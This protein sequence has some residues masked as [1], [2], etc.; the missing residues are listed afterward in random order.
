[1]QMTA[2]S[3]VDSIRMDMIANMQIPIPPTL[4]E[5]TAIA[6]TLLD[7]EALITSIEKLIDKKRSI[8]QGAMQQLLQ[9]KEG[10]EIKSIIELAENKKDLFNDGDWIESEY[11]TNKGIRLIQTGNIGIGSFVEK[12]N[13]KYINEESF[14]KLNCKELKVGD[15]LICRLAEPAGRAC[16][17]P[18]IGEERVITSVDVTIFRPNIQLVNRSFLNQIFSTNNWFNSISDLCGGTTHKRISRGALG[19]IKIQLPMIEEQTRIATILSDM[20]TEIT[21]L[22]Q[23]LEKYKKIKQGMMQELLT[24]K[25]RLV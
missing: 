12:E 18:N 20:D 15:L 5:Q 7:T 13:K 2:K 6:E 4:S 10:W 1:M 21:A 22:E 23:K 17:F 9:P 19:R 14:S 24:G 11:I 16:I 3:S 8:K 25:I